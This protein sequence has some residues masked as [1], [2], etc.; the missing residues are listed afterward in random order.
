MSAIDVLQSPAVTTLIGCL[1]VIAGTGIGAWIQRGHGREL[2]RDRFRH[3]VATRTADE[4]L[5]V[6]IQLAAKVAEAHRA[7]MNSQPTVQ[8]LLDSAKNYYYD[9]RFFF[10]SRLGAAFRKADE[11][12]AIAAANKDILRDNVNGFFDAVRADLLLED[13]AESV[14]RAVAPS[15]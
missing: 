1:G 3:E 9:N 4:R 5:K 13:L 15:K 6:Y 8:Q 12:L 7:K 14:T 10:S 11:S 2:E